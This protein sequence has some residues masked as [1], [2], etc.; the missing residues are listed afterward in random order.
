LREGS[1]NRCRGSRVFIDVVLVLP[2]SLK[3]EQLLWSSEVLRHKC[4]FRCE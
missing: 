2:V 4:S 1:I 3:L